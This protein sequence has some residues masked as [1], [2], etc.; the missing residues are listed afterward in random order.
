MTCHQQLRRTG[1]VAALLLLVAAASCSA[2]ETT[3]STLL[4]GRSLRLP[5]A[6]P[7][8][9]TDSARRRLLNPALDGSIPT[10][11]G[12]TDLKASDLNANVVKPTTVQAPP[13]VKVVPDAPPAP[14]SPAPAV[15]AP[16]TPRES[17]FQALPGSQLETEQ[18]PTK[19]RYVSFGN[20]GTV[21]EFRW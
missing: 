17:A 3:P 19:L 2:A 9:R 8:A 6:A 20:Y 15:P 7:A 4:R 18:Q 14:A 5:A 10:G 13:G 1:A 21:N 12:N 11:P 16:G